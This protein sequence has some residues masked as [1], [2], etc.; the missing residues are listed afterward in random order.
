MH[1]VCVCGCDVL[2]CCDGDVCA[3]GGARG[4]AGE[5]GVGEGEDGVVGDPFALDHPGCGVL[6]GL[7]AVGVIAK[8]GVLEM[9]DGGRK[10]RD[11]WREV[12]K[13]WVPCFS[14]CVV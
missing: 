9:G 8:G 3:G 11:G 7:V 2:A 4:V 10:M 1:P 5:R 13:P 14:D 6:G 12:D